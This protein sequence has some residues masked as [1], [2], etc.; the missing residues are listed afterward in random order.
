MGVFRVIAASV[1]VL[2]L[3]GPGS[4]GPVA[5]APS[6]EVFAAPP[7]LDGPRL[8]PDGTKIAAKMLIRGEQTLVV[9]PLLAN[10]KP[11]RVNLTGDSELNW[12][13][14]VN[15]D[16]L[17]AGVGAQTSI[18]GT[19]VYITRLVG[20]KADMTK[21]V[22][23]DWGNSGLSADGLLWTARDGSPKI[24]FQKETGIERSEEWNPAVF[25]ADVSTG[26][27]HRIING[28]DDISEWYA[29]GQ[30]NVRLGTGHSDRKWTLVYRADNKAGFSPVRNTYTAEH[31]PPIPWAYRPDGSAI[32][33]DNSSGFSAV[34]TMALPSFAIGERLYNVP[35]YDVSSIIPTPLEDGLIG[36]GFTDQTEKVAWL[37]PELKELQDG[38]DHTLGL[39]NSRIV[40]LSRDRHQLLVEVG[41]AGQAGGNYFW[42]TGGA[43]MQLIG[44]N[45]PVLKNRQLSSVRSIHYKAHD[46]QS[47]EA[48]L[49]LPDGIAPKSLP[50][51][52]MPHGGPYA[53]DSEQYDWWVQYLAAQGY[54]VIQPNYRGSTG[55]GTAFETLGEGQWGTGMQD[56]LNDALDYL[57]REGIADPKRVCIIGAS[58]GGYAAMRGAQRDGNRYRCAVSFAGVSDLSAM[59]RYDR[60]F[61]SSEK[62]AKDYWKKQAPDF[63][64]VSPRFH[65]A[66]FAAPILL[67]HGN[68][69]KR[70]PVAQS[71]WMAEELKKAGKQVDYIE[72]PL[73]DHHFTREADRLQFLKTMKSFLDRYNPA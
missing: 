63:T 67:V 71:R 39:G 11:A 2:F 50:L 25:E 51:I 60:K 21:T 66:D 23:I 7:L 36:V 38:L 34:H 55:Y 19:D 16:W 58:Y 64:A 14:W 70:V 33:I 41:N 26:R 52:V 57:A 72:Q 31:G 18:Y 56:D 59:M 12:W 1:A 40:S 65:A 62:S 48:I 42:D 45:N 24:L 10:A 22:P 17:I 4:A 49:T 37:D 8:S 68:K 30:G 61:L 73:G 32:V 35:G 53:R 3:A 6:V 13:R 15:D 5:N 20:L 28:R 44:F 9:Y 27:I 47:I 46:G 29:D 54:A 69:D 43:K